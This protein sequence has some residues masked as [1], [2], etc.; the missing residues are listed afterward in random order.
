MPSHNERHY[1]AYVVSTPAA[2]A[3]VLTGDE[4]TAAEGATRADVGTAAARTTRALSRTVTL[5][6][7][8]GAAHALQ[9]RRGVPAQIRRV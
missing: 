3:V 5:R 9:F 7:G 6:E 8:G 1:V 4:E 2:A